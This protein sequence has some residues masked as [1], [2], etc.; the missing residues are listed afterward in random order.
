MVRQE[1]EGSLMNGRL[2][3]LI[4]VS[5]R[6]RRNPVSSCS[7]K[8]S[9]PCVKIA[10]KGQQRDIYLITQGKSTCKRSTVHM[11]SKHDS[12]PERKSTGGQVTTMMTRTRVSNVEKED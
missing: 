6:P 3:P 11:R 1:V 7:M 5:M 2:D 4:V 8:A 12:M 10:L 9:Y